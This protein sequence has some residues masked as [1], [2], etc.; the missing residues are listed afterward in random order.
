MIR[1]DLWINHGFVSLSSPRKMQVFARSVGVHTGPGFGRSLEETDKAGESQGVTCQFGSGI[2]P[3]WIAATPFQRWR[4]LGR[5]IWATRPR[6]R[7]LSQ[8]PLCIVS[9]LIA[10]PLRR[11]DKFVAPSLLLVPDPAS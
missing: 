9:L 11:A 1:S 4:R 5:P 7:W 6:R 2:R 10:P 8:P 3:G